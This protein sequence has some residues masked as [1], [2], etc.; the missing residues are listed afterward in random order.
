[1]KRRGIISLFAAAVITATTG[2]LYSCKD[3]DDEMYTELSGQLIDQNTSLN[4]AINA[5]KDALEQLK[6]EL[7]ASKKECQDKL[8]ALKLELDKYLTKEEANQKFDEIAG[9]IGQLQGKINDL[10]GKIGQIDAVLQQHGNSIQDLVDAT[11]A[12]GNADK[13]FEGK[14]AELLTQMGKV[15]ST[16]TSHANRIEALEDLYEGLQNQSCEALNKRVDSLANEV[17]KIKAESEKLNTEVNQKLEDS[18]NYIDSVTTVVTEKVD[19]MDA[20]LGALEDA[21]KAADAALGNRIDA[22]VT[23]MNA[24]KAKVDA[25]DVK[26]T[27]ILNQRVTGVVLQGAYSP[28]VGYFAL[29]TGLKSNILA[30]FYGYPDYKGEFPSAQ[31]QNYVRQEQ[32]FTEREAELLGFADLQKTTWEGADCLINGEGNAGTLYL[33]VNPSS[34]DL[35][36]AKFKLVNSLGEDANV[37]LSPLKKSDK[38]LTFGYTRAGQ[39]NGFYE[40]KATIAESQVQAA[41]L[42]VDFNEL[43]EVVKDILSPSDGVDMT[44]VVSTI[45][46]QINDIAD[47]NAVEATWKDAL[48]VHSTYSDYG[49]AA[50]SVKPVSYSFMKDYNLE[51]FWGMDQANQL[52]DDIF[53]KIKNNLPQF[54]FDQIEIPKIDTI[55]LEEL[56]EELKAKFKITIKDTIVKKIELDHQIP[57][58]E[59]TIE[60]QTVV[61]PSKTV[62][63]KNDKGEVVGTTTIPAQRIEID[64]KTVWVDG[65]T[66]HI[67]KEL[68]IPIE[69]EYDMTEVIEELYDKMNKPMGDVN[70]MLKDLKRFLEE[71][72]QGLLDQ[73]NGIEDKLNGSVDSIRQEIGKYL[74][75]LNEKLCGLVNSVNDRIQPVLFVKTNKDFLLLSGV[76]NYPTELSRD[77]ILVPSSYTGEIIAPAYKKFV[78]VTDVVKGNKSAKAGDA[79]CVSVLK[80]ANNSNAHLNA[81][82]PGSELGIEVK[83]LK[84]GY[85]Y[86]LTFSAVD[87]HG[88]IANT[89]SYVVVK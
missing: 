16:T 19:N 83:N 37:T 69:L 14:L 21:Y 39:Q 53:G 43:K 56:D 72:L 71:D 40:A 34:A 49:I 59:I 15:D 66:I 54:G 52:L 47:A 57:G 28:V 45:Y 1:M 76:S 7:E 32:R 87:Y 80:N 41:K 25:L 22:L 85:V 75:K 79:E 6:G 82:I 30:A 23:D 3:Y 77:F 81:V 73:L 58:Q 60:G 2:S 24:L 42:R 62:E 61:I 4:D 11:V 64:G 8:D 89:K 31:S 63:V 26:F 70:E 74:D 29:P 13:V 33:T 46:S 68:E 50:V 51:K 36:G 44:N 55:K 67:E 20:K 5:Q 86:E 27:G 48:G 10:T 17:A 65:T 18:K 12:L 38:K 84:A 35:S 78:A 88:M 9:Q